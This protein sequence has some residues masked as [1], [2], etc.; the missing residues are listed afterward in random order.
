MANNKRAEPSSVL[1][2]ALEHAKAVRAAG[3]GPDA[4]IQIS[5]R[6]EPDQVEALEDFAAHF[7]FR[8][9]ASASRFIVKSVLRE[10]HNFLHGDLGAPEG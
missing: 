10:F 7:E 6:L 2:D 3:D 8:S 4:G 9:R 1:R 5:F